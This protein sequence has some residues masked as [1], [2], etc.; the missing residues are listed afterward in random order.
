MADTA[1]TA[2][3]APAPEAPT[4][5]PALEDT[6]PQKRGRGRPPKHQAAAPVS[7][8]DAPAAT[9][10]GPGRPKGA[11]KKP[12]VNFDGEAL[13]SLAKQVQGLHQLMA[14]ATGIPELMLQE[15]EAIMLGGAIAQVCEEY[16]LSLSGKTGALLQLAAAGAM[17][18]APRF[19]AVTQRIKRQR[20]QAQQND[21]FEGVPHVAPAAYT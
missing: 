13:A 7:P 9:K 14:L 6:A 4:V 19:M 3:P 8:V 17:I 21:A 5:A 1:P 20:E 15:G 12:K 11:S 2:S 18:Y 10:P 16:D